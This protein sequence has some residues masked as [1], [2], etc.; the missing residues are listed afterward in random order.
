MEVTTRTG[1]YEG[2]SAREQGWDISKIQMPKVYPESEVIRSDMA[3]Y[4]KE[5]QDF[6][7]EVNQL[8]NSL[9]NAGVLDNTIIIITSDNGMPFPRAKGIYMT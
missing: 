9:K 7:E 5:V 6:D 4:L 1:G 3:D 2:G 8:I